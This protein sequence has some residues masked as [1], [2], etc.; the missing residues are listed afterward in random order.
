MKKALMLTALLVLTGLVPNNQ[1]FAAYSCCGQEITSELVRAL[2]WTLS[3]ELLTRGVVWL[4]SVSAETRCSSIGRS[5][6]CL[7]L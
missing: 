4:T 7:V 5:L 1:R 3:D 6:L 2:G